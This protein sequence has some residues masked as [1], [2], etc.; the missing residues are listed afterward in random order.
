MGTIPLDFDVD[1]SRKADGP[2]TL[3]SNFG[4]SRFDAQARKGGA[5]ADLGDKAGDIATE[6]AWRNKKADLKADGIAANAK[7]Q[8]LTEEA[9]RQAGET[10][11]PDEI[12][13]IYAGIHAKYSEWINGKNDGG[14]PNVRWSEQRNEL[15]RVTDAMQIGYDNR[16]NGRIAEVGRRNTNAK[17][18]QAQYDAE[19]IG[20][21]DGISTAVQIRVDNGT[22]TSEEA[23]VE[24]RAAF[25]R[26]DMVVA[27]NNVSAIELMP[28]DQAVKAAQTFEKGLTAKEKDG[29]W[30]MFP[31]LDVTQRNKIIKSSREAA[32]VSVKRQKEADELKQLQ[33]NSAVMDFW[34]QNGRMPSPAETLQMN[35]TQ[36]TQDAILSGKY[37]RISPAMEFDSAM[38]FSQEMYGYRTSSDPTGKQKLEYARRIEG[39]ESQATKSFLNDV[40]KRVTSTEASDVDS[41]V[42]AQ[43][44]D[45]LSKDFKFG[46]GTGWSTDEKMDQIALEKAAYAQWVKEK[47]PTPQERLAY[48]TTGRF[49][50]LKKQK[51]LATFKASLA[52]SV[53]P[54]G[55]TNINE[56]L[57]G[58]QSQYSQ[59]NQP[60]V[61]GIKKDPTTGRV[62]ARQLDDGTIIEVR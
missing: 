15:V 27:G 32:R 41:R 33:S 57:T 14:A 17:S 39:F 3:P 59:T 25:V 35:L 55:G 38:S 37:E 46:W 4:M 50:D 1:Y 20:D 62:I 9:D 2:A 52:R 18:K 40:L 16:A 21:F 6:Y 48:T 19:Q 5:I 56:V 47:N 7:L 12:R 51:D 31:N 58:I 61:I 26:T 36:E 10:E 8:A 43:I 23:E 22:L 13:N 60:R 29:S 49:A 34:S 11:D 53:S 30:T 28:A 44:E 24:R 45:A 54:A 42:N